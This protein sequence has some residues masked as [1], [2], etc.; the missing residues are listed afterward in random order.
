LDEAGNIFFFS[1]HTDD[2][3]TFPRLIA[4][5]QNG[6]TL[7]ERTY[8]DVRLNGPH[9]PK[10]IWDGH[11]LQ[12][13]WIANDALYHARA[14]STG[15]F[16]NPP[17]TLND[18]IPVGQYDLSADASGGIAIWFAGP[19]ESPGLWALVAEDGIRTPILA[20]PEGAQPN[21]QFDADGILH[22]LWSRPPS[23]PGDV[24][25]LYAAYE[26]GHFEPGREQI[27]ATA[28]ETSNAS[29]SGPIMGLDDENIYIFWS[30]S[31]FSGLEA[32]TVEAS[33]QSFPKRN[34]SA[35]TQP[36]FLA[37]PHAFTLPYENTDG[38]LGGEQRVDLASSPELGGTHIATVISNDATEEELVVGILARVGYSLRKSRFQVGAVYLKHGLAKDYQQLSFTPT[39]SSAPMILSDRDGELHLT[40]LEKGE[41]PGWAVYYA[42]TRLEF[43]AAMRGLNL[44]D[45]GRLS[46]ETA[47]GLA[48]GALLLPVGMAWL[49]PALLTIVLTSSLRGADER[50]TNIPTTLSLA[51][52]LATLWA[53]KVMVLPGVQSY[54]PFSAWLPI[55]SNDL[56]EFLRLGVPIGIASL[57]VLAAWTYLSRKGE[58]SVYQFMAV[59][60]IV[61][62]ILTMAVYGVL[63]LGAI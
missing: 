12:L 34:P 20:D 43:Q 54:V 46:A 8:Q 5:D 47:F 4:L 17:V 50:L 3:A 10:L 40:W 31:F 59:Y 19:P 2:E 21:L 36:Q 33:Y 13:F 42:S 45:V 55:I 29:L 51:L 35:Q 27:V 25:F 37:V 39:S 57:G 41:V 16:L 38:A 53:V 48:T 28:R 32:G 9:T 44:Q 23:S 52:A 11:Q 14:D 18:E 61:D 58:G 6:E 7:W 24:P 56:Q 30:L 62:G 49:L 26:G 60:A 15:A 63:I 22:A 1:F